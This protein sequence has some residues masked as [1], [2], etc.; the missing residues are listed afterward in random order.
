MEEVVAFLAGNLEADEAEPFSGHDGLL[1]FTAVHD[2]CKSHGLP[3]Q[4]CLFFLVGQFVSERFQILVGFVQTRTNLVDRA[5]HRQ[6]VD[7]DIRFSFAFSQKSLDDQHF[8][9]DRILPR[10]LRQEFD[11]SDEVIPCEIPRNRNESW[12]FFCIGFTCED[13][14]HPIAACI[15]PPDNTVNQRE[16]NLARLPIYRSPSRLAA[17]ASSVKSRRNAQNAGHYPIKSPMAVRNLRAAV[18]APVVFVSP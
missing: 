11:L 5:E 15:P 17:S 9:V 14:R 13:G 6:V 2:R 3:P 4:P 8:L 7:S 18:A 16:S 12:A 10:I 1:T